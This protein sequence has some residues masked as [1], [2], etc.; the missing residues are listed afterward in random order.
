MNH[1][2][3][4]KLS[5][6]ITFEN[7]SIRPNVKTTVDSNLPPDVAEWQQECYKLLTEKVLK[8][9]EVTVMQKPSPKSSKRRTSL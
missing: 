7:G 1:H 5:F 2:R 9:T 8:R 3:R 6:K 4:C